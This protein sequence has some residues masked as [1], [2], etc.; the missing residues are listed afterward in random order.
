MDWLEFLA[1]GSYGAYV[2]SAYAL[3]AVVLILNVVLPL[4]RRRSLP[5]ELREYYRAHR[6]R[7]ETSS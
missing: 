3:A 2:W 7:D 1:M 4:R 5:R 6:S